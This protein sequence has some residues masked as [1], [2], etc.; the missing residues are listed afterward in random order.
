MKARAAPQRVRER[1]SR[2]DGGKNRDG[3]GGGSLVAAKW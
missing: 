3:E 2:R 1:R